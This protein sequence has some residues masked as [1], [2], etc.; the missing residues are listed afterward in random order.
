MVITESPST[1]HLRCTEDRLCFDS[2]SFRSLHRNDTTQYV[3]LP[4]S[5]APIVYTRVLDIS[6]PAVSVKIYYN[7]DF[8]NESLTTTSR[9]S[10]DKPEKLYKNIRTVIFKTENCSFTIV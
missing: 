6:L 7:P 5:N 10:S 9:I 3:Y 4:R 2:S 8:K 1:I